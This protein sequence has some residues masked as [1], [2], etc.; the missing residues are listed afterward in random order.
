M[1]QFRWILVFWVDKFAINCFIFKTFSHFFIKSYSVTVFKLWPLIIQLRVRGSFLLFTVILWKK[2]IFRSIERFISSF[3]VMGSLWLYENQNICQNG[4]V[5]KS[6]ADVVKLKTAAFV[7]DSLC[8]CISD[9]SSYLAKNLNTKVRGTTKKY[10]W[11]DSNL[12]AFNNLYSSWLIGM[13]DF[14]LKC[15]WHGLCKML[16]E[17]KA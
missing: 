9:L 17:G 8:V 11:L 15:S 13:M 14:N 2:L 16:H 3:H 5:M 7:K 10:M 4:Q 12:S 1:A 6:L